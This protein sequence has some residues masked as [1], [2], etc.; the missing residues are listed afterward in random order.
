LTSNPEKNTA[1][2]DFAARHSTSLGSQDRRAENLA[3]GPAE[4][5]ARL[6]LA[7]DYSKAVQVKI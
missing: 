6:Q 5:L 1:P 2:V 4:I 7:E 3:C